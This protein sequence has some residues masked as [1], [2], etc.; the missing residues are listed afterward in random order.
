MKRPL[1]LLSRSSLWLLEWGKNKIWRNNDVSPL[2]ISKTIV[3]LLQISAPDNG[4][5]QFIILWKYDIY[6]KA[7]VGP[8]NTLGVHC[9]CPVCGLSKQ[10]FSRGCQCQIRPFAVTGERSINNMC[11]D[12]IKSKP[13]V[14][15]GVQEPHM[16]SSLKDQMSSTLS[17]EKSGFG[18]DLLLKMVICSNEVL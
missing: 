16:N 7:N 18:L 10:G 15:A 3:T 9:Q 2:V 11:Y 17:R 5:I 6:I 8:Y 13:L 1:L 4:C 14:C 12:T